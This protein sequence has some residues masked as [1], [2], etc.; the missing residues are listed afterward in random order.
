MQ[1][2]QQELIQGW[3]ASDLVSYWDGLESN[4]GRVVGWGIRQSRGSCLHLHFFRMLKTR[5]RV[6][7]ECCKGH[8]I[9]GG[10]HSQMCRSTPETPAVTVSINVALWMLL[11]AHSSP[12]SVENSFNTPTRAFKSS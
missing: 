6:R 3:Q 1:G 10:I 9:Q 7:Q 11:C 8:K 4:P 12:G 2:Q 5:A